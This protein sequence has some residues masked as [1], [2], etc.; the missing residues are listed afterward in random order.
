MGSPVPNYTLD[1][2][3]GRRRGRSNKQSQFM[4]DGTPDPASPD[5]AEQG[6]LSYPPPLLRCPLCRQGASKTRAAALPITRQ[7]AGENLS[8]GNLGLCSKTRTTPT[9][10]SRPEPT[11]PRRKIDPDWKRARIAGRRGAGVFIRSSAWSS[12]SAASR[13]TPPVLRLGYTLGP[14][15]RSAPLAGANTCARDMRPCPRSS[16]RRAIDLR[17]RQTRIDRGKRHRTALAFDA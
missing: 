17:Q 9:R 1:L 16:A 6:Q 12:G 8:R 14:C 4:P 13:V 3:G 5:L 11:T 15:P 7:R 2:W 10:T